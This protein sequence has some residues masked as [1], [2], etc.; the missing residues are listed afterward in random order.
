MTRDACDPDARHAR[1][2]HAEGDDWSKL[3]NSQRK[4]RPLSSAQVKELAAKSNGAA[5]GRLAK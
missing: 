5:C 4:D 1:G 3:P 2:M